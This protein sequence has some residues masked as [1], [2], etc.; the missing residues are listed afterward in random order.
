MPQRN[1]PHSK[2]LQN[3]AANTS[4]PG[5]SSSSSVDVN[6]TSLATATTNSRTYCKKQQFYFS[7][8]THDSNALIAMPN[9][10]TCSYLIATFA[11]AT[12]PQ[13]LSQ[14]TPITNAAAKLQ[15]YKQNPLQLLLY[16]PNPQIAPAT[17]CL[18]TKSQQQQRPPPCHM[19]LGIN[20]TSAASNATANA[21]VIAVLQYSLQLRS[22]R[23]G[24]RSIANAAS[25]ANATA[26]H[27]KSLRL[28]L[29]RTNH[30]GYC[31]STNEIR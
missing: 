7:N 22:K 21:A 30:S 6:T 9:C 4:A 3:E 29:Y 25:I 13:K 26:P 31:S 5:N 18:Q 24:K 23:H 11:K 16:K 8:A 19:K 27:D 12:A 20:P 1:Q 17:A 14:R 2:V 28:Q 15:L 10:N